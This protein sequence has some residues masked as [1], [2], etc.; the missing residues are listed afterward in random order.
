M[1]KSLVKMLSNLN[2]M[3]C[4]A[5]VKEQTLLPQVNLPNFLE[6]SKE[7]L[8]RAHNLHVSNNEE[9]DIV[10]T[11][12]TWTFMHEYIIH[13]IDALVAITWITIKTL[14][15]Q[16]KIFLI[17]TLDNF[18]FDLIFGSILMYNSWA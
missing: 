13:N 10:V 8:L 9:E 6:D 14:G 15:I 7:Q 12:W 17:E 1:S 16:N 2:T 3:M 5:F 4:H 18:G 11:K